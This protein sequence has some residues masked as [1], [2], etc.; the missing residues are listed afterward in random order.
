V[1]QE[2]IESI[3][4]TVHYVHSIWI[5]MLIIGLCGG[6]LAWHKDHDNEDSLTEHFITHIITGILATFMVPLF[7]QMIGSTL[8]KT[9]A[10]NHHQFYVFVGFC[11]AAAFISH[12]FASKVS[13]RMM[14]DTQKKAKVAE[15]K[16]DEALLKSESNF[17]EGL[18][19][20]GGIL[21]QEENYDKAL[22]YINEYLDHRP[23]DA[24][25]LWRKAYILKRESNVSEAYE[26]VSK[27]IELKTDPIALIYFNRACYGCLLNKSVESVIKDL[28]HAFKI[29]DDGKVVE[30]I[31]NDIEKDLKLFM[32]NTIFLDY[33]SSK[34]V[35]IDTEVG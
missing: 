1:T 22:L 6:V 34:G 35:Q 28:E 19:T 8:L 29:D 20:R 15:K 5:V 16:A 31:K 17:V 27:A 13:D 33:L 12:N 10:P 18:K 30:Y 23:E 21:F 14:Q 25:M 4:P 24:G 11:S 9:L 26:L 32:K 7:L 3:V 2:E